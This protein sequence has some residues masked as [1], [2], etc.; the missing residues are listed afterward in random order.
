MCSAASLAAVCFLPAADE[1]CACVTFLRELFG[2]YPG[3]LAGMC[4]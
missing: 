4:C 2:A 1:V 3:L